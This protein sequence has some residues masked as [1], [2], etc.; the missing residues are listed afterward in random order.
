MLI[1]LNNNISSSTS[2]SSNFSLPR[3]QLPDGEPFTVAQVRYWQPR[4]TALL[5]AGRRISVSGGN[6]KN[7]RIAIVDKKTKQKEKAS[8]PSVATKKPRRKQIVSEDDA[9]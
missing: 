6:G 7:I 3:V 2:L 9:Q 1:C 8:T 5:P 4:G